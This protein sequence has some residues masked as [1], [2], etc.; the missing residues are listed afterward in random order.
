MLTEI[1]FSQEKSNRYEV[2]PTLLPSYI[3]TVC[4]HILAI[5]KTILFV[6]LE[7]SGGT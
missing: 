4:V 6:K 1:L 2:L 5:V 3:L 7:N